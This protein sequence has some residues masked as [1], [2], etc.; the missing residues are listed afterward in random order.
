MQQGRKFTGI[1]S[2]IKDNINLKQPHYRPGRALSVPGG[3]GSQI[4]RPS[5]HEGGKPYAPASFTPQEIFLVLISVRSWVKSRA[6]VR[7]EGLCQ[8]KI[9]M[10]TSGIEL[11]IF[12]LVVQ[13]LNQ[14][15]HHVSSKDNIVDFLMNLTIISNYWRAY[16][17]CRLCPSTYW[18]LKNSKI[19]HFFSFLFFD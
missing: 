18:C 6:I 3:W 9:P 15:R 13:C 2:I 5:T 8:W 11:A 14:L 7:P 19:W 10:T 1:S 16:G 12:Q 17:F 4:S